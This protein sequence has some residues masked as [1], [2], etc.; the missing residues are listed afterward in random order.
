MVAGTAGLLAV[1]A[2]LALAAGAVLRRSAGAITA[3]VGLLIV[4]L[5]LGAIL[6]QGP[7]DWLLRLT[8]AAAFGL[9]Q[10]IPHYSQ[11][12]SICQ[13]YN[14]CYPLAPWTGFAVLCVWAAVALGIATFVLRRRDT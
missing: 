12:T 9:Q 2:I 14:G 6:P 10:G 7:A 8:P 13:P 5:I 11:V 1:A 3:A 4:P